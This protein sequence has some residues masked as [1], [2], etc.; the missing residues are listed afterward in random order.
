M[1]EETRDYCLDWLGLH[2]K[3]REAFFLIFSTLFVPSVNAVVGYIYIQLN[4]GGIL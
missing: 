1:R 3:A 4:S 2:L